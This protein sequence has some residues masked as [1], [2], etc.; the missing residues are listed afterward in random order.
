[1]KTIALTQGDFTPAAGGYLMY[2][3]TQK[4][5]QDLAL[6]LQ[7]AYGGDALHS[8][9]GSILPDMVGQPLTPTLQSQILTEVNRILNNYVT[10]QN[11][12]IIQDN[13]TRSVSSYSTDDV[14]NSITSLSAQQVYDSILVNIGLQTISRQS[15]SIQQVIS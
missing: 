9:W 3:G 13:A 14:V 6:A 4:I 10:V 1:M 2:E 7:E 5:R 8:A 11:A 12:R 15:I